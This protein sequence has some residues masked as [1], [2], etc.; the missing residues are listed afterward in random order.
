MFLFASGVALFT[1]SNSKI[2]LPPDNPIRKIILPFLIPTQPVN[3][4]LLGGDKVNKNTDT[5]ML[6]NF[7]P[8]TM[9]VSVLSIPRDTKVIIENQERKINF[10]YPRGGPKLAV[11][12]VSKLLNVNI[13]Y[14][15]YIDISVFRN[16]ID[17]LGGVKNFYI[18]VDMDYDDASQNL[19]IH[20]KKGYQDLNGEQA[21]E[22]MRFRKGKHLSQIL[23]YYDGS[24]NK[25]IDAQQSLLKELVRQKATISYLPKINSI[26][27]ELFKNLET[28]ISMN[29]LLKLTP[30]F[31]NFQIKNLAFFTVPGV[32]EEEK[33]YYYICNIDK[34]SKIVSNYFQAIANNSS[35][36]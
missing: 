18:P 2:E 26:I 9:K 1:F 16:I 31:A 36:Q 6:I 24:D 5:I 22:F 14:Y 3:V 19:H 20:F 28:D 8:E 17:M 15:F 33:L 7:N 10:A 29:E 25:R 13:N 34:T 11:D 32:P 21:E 4:L 12:T 23:N 30:N 27:S 35:Q